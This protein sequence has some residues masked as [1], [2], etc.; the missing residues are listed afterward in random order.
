MQRN[1]SESFFSFSRTCHLQ[2]AIHTNDNGGYRSVAHQAMPPRESSRNEL[3]MEA[4]TAQGIKAP[5]RNKAHDIRGSKP[6]R[7]GCAAATHGM[8]AQPKHG[9]AA[10][11]LEHSPNMATQAGDGLL[12]EAGQLVRGQSR[13]PKG[14]AALA[15]AC[16]CNHSLLHL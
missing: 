4:H 7:H 1:M 3:S 16:L 2:T 14:S 10:Q 11:T 5:K 6:H 15:S 8:G 9:N 13:R 12:K